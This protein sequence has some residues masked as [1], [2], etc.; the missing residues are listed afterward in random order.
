MNRPLL[1]VVVP[2][3]NVSE[4][5]A[6]CLD[7]LY[8]QETTDRIEIILVNDGSTD[9]SLSFC[10]E[11]ILKYPQTLLVDKPNGG[12]SDAR[13]AGTAVATGEYIYYLDSDDWI[14]P[15]ALMTL[16]RFAKQHQ[17]D[18][19]QGG[20]YYAYAD[21]LLQDTRL[22]KSTT[23]I[24]LTREEG[25][26]ALIENNTVKNFAWGKLY[27]TEIPRLHPFRKGVYFEDAYWQHLVMH[28]VKRYGIVAQPLYYYRQRN[29]SISGAFSLRNMD[30]LKGYE[31]RID[32]LRIHY[33][34]YLDLQLR[35]YWDIAYSFYQM[36]QAHPEKEVQEGYRTYWEQIGLDY[37]N[38]FQRAL[39]H[40]LT[41][42]LVTRHSIALP[43]YLFLKRI[44]SRFRP[45]SFQRI[46]LL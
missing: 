13:N 38:D 26:K 8:I 45:S 7:S 20:F 41:Y 12:L 18:V 39:K 30:L 11:Y 32:F 10:K 31:E 1:S 9:N 14:A 25:M 35:M 34:H 44:W 19:V 33:P 27:R 22:N 42:Q 28:K 23:P 2:I 17:C 24:L 46:T 36:G 3:Y 15:D 37:H 6:T 43:F 5:L 40:S 16:Y 21:H 4:Y 29:E